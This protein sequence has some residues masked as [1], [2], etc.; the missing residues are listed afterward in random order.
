MSDL[1]IKTEGLVKHY[2]LGAETVRAVRGVDLEIH[3]G[4]FVSVMGPSG[5]GKSTFMNMIGCLDTPT[6]SGP[7]GEYGDPHVQAIESTHPGIDS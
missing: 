7:S 2:V 5:S 4:E 6:R 3:E 1:I